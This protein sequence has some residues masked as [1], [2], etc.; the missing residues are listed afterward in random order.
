MQRGSEI[1]LKS[2]L[3]AIYLNARGFALK[4]L[5]ILLFQRKR[6]P[7]LRNI[8]SIL[9][10]RVDRVGDMVLSTPAFRAIKAALPEVHLTVMAS[11]AN[12][13]V[14]KNN[15]DVDE[16]IVYD[17]SAGLPVKKKFIGGLR[18]RHFDLAV[19]PYTDYELKTAWL[20]GMSGAVHR[21]GHAAFGRE[22]FFNSPS[23]EIDGEK[24]FVYSA[25][26]LLKRIDISSE[27]REPAI[28][29]GADEEAWADQWVK[30]NEFEGKKIVAIHPGAYY[31][32]QRW[33]PEYYAGLIDMI[34]RKTPLEVVLLG[35]LPDAIVIEDILAGRKPPVCVSVQDDIR[36]FFAI[37]SQC[38][39][40][41]C[42][43]SGPLHCA[44]ALGIPTISFIGPT[45][46]ERW[47]PI[48]DIH[49]VLRKD[50]LPC[51]GCNLGY[52]KIK[53]HDCMRLIEPKEVFEI[54]VKQCF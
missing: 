27:N 25:L 37:L 50:D 5:S 42:N 40:L 10:I 34:R 31:E 7:A 18:S 8:G 47:M 49:R 15:P 35:G 32:T 38:R 9:F 14:L 30:E 23:Q 24:H 19:D 12:A 54:I 36:K 3:K 17:R 52:C 20:A 46:K 48:G 21:I 53:T 22:I 16:V 11:P 43:N 33:L 29:L 41:V 44:V 2:I 45:V 51:I 28:Y 39:L 4:S 1:S 13:P 6:F 26:D